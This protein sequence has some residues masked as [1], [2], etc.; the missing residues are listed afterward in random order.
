MAYTNGKFTLRI[1]K[2]NGED[3]YIMFESKAAAEKFVKGLQDQ[4]K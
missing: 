4:L 1:T 3:S 2:A